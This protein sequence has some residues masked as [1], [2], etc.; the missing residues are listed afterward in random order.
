MSA[1]VTLSM[2]EVEALSARAARG[3]GYS[4]GHCEECGV[5]SAWLAAHGFDW[6]SSLLSRL[7]G[8]AGAAI[9]PAPLKWLSGG[10][11]CALRCGTAIVDF[12]DLPEGLGAAGLEVGEVLDPAL[13]VP[14]LAQAVRSADR[15]YDCLVDGVPWLRIQPDGLVF[16]LA[17]GEAAKA[18]AS[19]SLASTDRPSVAPCQP[20]ATITISRSHY[21]D[22]NALAL[23]MT[24]PATDASARGAGGLGSD[25]D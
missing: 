5:A 3:V 21:N 20:T 4:W 16:R 9:R 24:V 19:L 22:L 11:V 10:P 17:P 15:T 14:F 18:R 25:N 6:P 1:Q 13:L 23:R 7:R 8:D 2:P 12:A